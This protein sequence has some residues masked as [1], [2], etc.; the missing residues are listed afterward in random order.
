MVIVVVVFVVLVVVDVIVV[1]QTPFCMQTVF[2]NQ[3]LD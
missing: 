1:V 2:F 3:F